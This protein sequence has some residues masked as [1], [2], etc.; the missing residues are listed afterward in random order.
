MEQPGLDFQDESIHSRIEQAEWIDSRIEKT[1]LA[2][3]N[4]IDYS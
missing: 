3:R 2:F 4:G 1:S